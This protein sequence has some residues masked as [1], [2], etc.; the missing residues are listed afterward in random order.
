MKRNSTINGAPANC[1]NGAGAGFSTVGECPPIKRADCPPELRHFNPLKSYG[2]PGT[3]GTLTTSCWDINKA[4][5]SPI[6]VMLDLSGA[7]NNLFNGW[8][9]TGTLIKYS[10]TDNVGEKKSAADG[11]VP[12]SGKG[13]TTVSDVLPG[14]FGA[15]DKRLMGLPRLRG[16][17]GQLL[18]ADQGRP[19]PVLRIL[20]CL[21]RRPGLRRCRPGLQLPADSGHRLLCNGVSQFCC[22]FQQLR[23]LLEQV[24]GQQGW[25][26][27]AGWQL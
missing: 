17:V 27:A 6:Q 10:A 24:R 20:E 2:T 22:E 7:D 11:G 4:L 5:S 13:P 18:Q 15:S 8:D 16:P 9:G 1:A 21:D 19:R 3:A 25:L 14:I 23:Q 26:P 12:W